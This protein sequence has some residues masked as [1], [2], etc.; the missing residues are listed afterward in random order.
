MRVELVNSPAAKRDLSALLSG[1]DGVISSACTVWSRPRADG[2]D[3][4]ALPEEEE[5]EE[6][7]R[8]TELTLSHLQTKIYTVSLADPS[9]VM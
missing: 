2:L 7:S 6:V 3:H 1:A 9:T 4:R 8:L 5:E